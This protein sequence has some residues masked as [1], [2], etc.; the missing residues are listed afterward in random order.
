LAHRCDKCN[1]KD[2]TKEDIIYAEIGCNK[3]HSY[4]ISHFIDE[5]NK[6]K[7]GQIELKC[8][9]CVEENESNDHY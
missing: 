4:C 1:K 3:N 8:Y 5:I 6:S 2:L 9:K 7:D